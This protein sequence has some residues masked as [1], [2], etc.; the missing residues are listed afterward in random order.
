MPHLR[1][2]NKL[3][4]AFALAMLPVAILAGVAIQWN[5]VLAEEQERAALLG[6]ADTAA[7]EADDYIRTAV[8]ELA[9]A[10][11]LLPTE[12]AFSSELRFGRLYL[13]RGDFL[14]IYS[15]DTSGRTRRTLFRE[16]GR[17]PGNLPVEVLA[18][19]LESREWTAATARYDRAGSF[20]TILVARPQLDAS[21]SI[22]GIMVGRLSLGRLQLNLLST[23]G[24]YQILV[25]DEYARVLGAPEGW[26]A[27]PSHASV[28][29]GLAARKFDTPVELADE[30]GTWLAA[31][32]QLST[33]PWTVTVIAPDRFVLSA[34]AVVGGG[35]V[36]LLATLAG[37]VAAA[38][39]LSRLMLRPLSELA[40]AARSLAE[41]DLSVRAVPQSSGETEELAL[42]FNSMA[43]TLEETIAGLKEQRFETAA[44]AQELRRLLER[45]THLQ[46]VERARLAVDVHDGATQLMVAAQLELDAVRLTDGE[47]SRADKVEHAAER[48]HQAIAAMRRVTAGLHPTTLGNLGAEMALRRLVE[49][50]FEDTAVKCHV[51]LDLSP[52]LLDRDAEIALFRIAQESLANVRNHSHA[53]SVTIVA[54]ASP[55][56]I[57]LRVADNG[58]G[59]EVEAP[60]LFAEPHLGLIAMRERALSVGGTLQVSSVLGGGTCVEFDLP[61][62][63]PS[64]LLGMPSSAS[65]GG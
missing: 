16:D 63:I 12:S 56:G 48:V 5:N 10:A 49:D 29:A 55:N 17:Q 57:H 31:Y 58:R 28:T 20:P 14:D 32:S 38:A 41:G 2:T 8:S 50:T 27:A 52:D 21:G 51:E 33:V 30:S 62:R 35:M 65:T 46:E 40:A 61:A 44:R 3:A 7:R 42:A 11:P 54:A 1:L 53:D 60:T 13:A 59:F 23:A 34:P 15:V 24:S 18:T 9:V 39:V 45:I 6:A 47:A 37:S 64:G 36:L 19:V 43:G 26:Y 22:E 4:V 25:L